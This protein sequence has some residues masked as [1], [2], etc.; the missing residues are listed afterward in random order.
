M[1][2]VPDG[3]TFHKWI[4][5][6]LAAWCLASWLTAELVHTVYAVTH[7]SSSLTNTPLYE[8]TPVYIFVSLSADIPVF[9][10]WIYG[11]TLGASPC[12]HVD[13]SHVGTRSSW[14]FM[15]E[16]WLG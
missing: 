12:V 4:Q 6:A 10:T 9:P 15:Q 2:T 16:E 14:A 13:G 5:T 7:E 11:S 8:C 1:K 3:G